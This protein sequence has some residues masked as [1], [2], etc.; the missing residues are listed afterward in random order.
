MATAEASS[1]LARGARG[2]FE[3]K[4][5]DKHQEHVQYIE[6]IIQGLKDKGEREEVDQRTQARAL[7]TRD[8]RRDTAADGWVS[9]AF[10]SVEAGH[11]VVSMRAVPVPV[12]SPTYLKP[13]KMVRCTPVYSHS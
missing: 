7:E 3:D 4:H 1:V 11:C 10:S 8:C 9:S 13:I 6:G 5:K 12:S 2:D